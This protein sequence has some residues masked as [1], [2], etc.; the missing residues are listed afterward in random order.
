MPTRG[1]CRGNRGDFTEAFLWSY[2]PLSGFVRV[3]S[4]SQLLS[5]H[6]KL[7]KAKWIALL[8]PR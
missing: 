4:S 8:L 5:Q 3:L 1:A 7:E 2:T 6:Y